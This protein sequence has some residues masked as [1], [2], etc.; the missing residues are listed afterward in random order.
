MHRQL[1][2]D[3]VI[4]ELVEQFEAMAET[5]AIDDDDA[6]SSHIMRKAPVRIA[7]ILIVGARPDV[8]NALFV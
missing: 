7:A 6:L 8:L 5:G 1:D 2:R 3:L 4:H